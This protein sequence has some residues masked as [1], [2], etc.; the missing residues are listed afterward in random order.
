MKR[1]LFLMLFF[2]SFPVLSG[3]GIGKVSIEYA[4][5]WEGKKLLFFYTDSHFSPPNCNTY[6]DR[7]VVDLSTEEGMAI[8]RFVFS[9]QM[10]GKSIKLTGTNDCN[11]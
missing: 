5:A 1:L 8:Y 9:A 11:L 6:N 2:W 4:G 7:W 10:A 3:T